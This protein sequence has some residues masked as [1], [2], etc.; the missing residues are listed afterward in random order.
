MRTATK[1]GRPHPTTSMFQ[2]SDLLHPFLLAANYPNASPALL[3]LSFKAMKTLLEANAVSPGDGINL[4][5]V[6]M[7]QTQ[8]VV[9]YGTVSSNGVG[10]DKSSTS[11]N[12]KDG[13][14][15]GGWVGSLISSSSN[16][17]SAGTAEPPSAATS[18]SIMSAV[19]SSHGQAGTPHLNN[20]ELDK[21]ALDILSCLL[22]LLELRDLPVPGEQW[23]Q[24]FSIC[25]HLYE[26]KSKVIRQA[27]KSTLPQVLGLLF[28][29]ENATLDDFKL[30]TWN[31]LVQCLQ[32]SKQ[33]LNGAFSACHYDQDGTPQPPSIPLALELLGGIS[34][35]SPKYLSRNTIDVL[36]QVLEQLSISSHSDPL[37]FIRVLQF[38]MLLFQSQIAN[39]DFAA[40]CR[41]LLAK[42]AKPI[43]KAT[44]SLRS[45]ADFEDGYIFQSGGVASDRKSDGTVKRSRNQSLQTL[46]GMSPTLLSKAAL[47]T[48]TILHIIQDA[49]LKSLWSHESILVQLLEA[50]SD[51]CTIGA[52]CEAHMML[53]VE[54][55]HSPK[56]ILKLLEPLA[57]NDTTNLK[58]WQQGFSDSGCI[59]S[60]AI[61]GDAMRIGFASILKM[62]EALDESALEAGFAPSLSVLQ[63]YLKRFPSSSLIV[64]RALSGYTSLARVTLESGDLLRRALLSSL[65]KLS[66][67]RWGECDAS[68]KLQDHN[69]AALICLVTIIHRFYN[70]IGS[71]WQIIFQ[72]FQELSVLSIA[73]PHLSDSAYIGALSISAVFG[74]FAAFSTCLS[75]DSLIELVRCLKEVAQ[76]EQTTVLV[77]NA[78]G[79]TS[80][81]PIPNRPASFDDSTKRSSSLDNAEADATIGSK[82]M[83]L[84]ARAVYGKENG[85]EGEDVPVAERTKANYFHDYQQEFT[86]RLRSSKQPLKVDE[87]PFS[88]ILLADIAMTNS[89]RYQHCGFAVIEQLCS[90]AM[91]SP[92]VQQFS[93]NT[94]AMIIMTHISGEGNLPVVS[95]GRSKILYD[96]PR[97][98]QY[99]A[100]GPTESSEDIQNA[101]NIA[102]SQLFAPLCN[103]V[104][105]AASHTVVE[106]SLI[107]L[108]LIL[109][110]AGHNLHEDVWS[111]LIDAVGSLSSDGRSAPE[112]MECNAIGFKC[113]KLIVDDFLHQ[114]DASLAARRSLL[115][116]CASF[117][118]SRHDMNTSLTAIGLLW[119]I[120]DQD[121]G[122]DA[123]DVSGSHVQNI[124]LIKIEYF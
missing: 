44:E 72:T 82:L 1:E 122:G 54:A 45:Q 38:T 53:L 41:A 79:G 105:A 112:W 62:I 23:V 58:W 61:F 25:C 91:D 89:F 59:D 6:W 85:S 34:Q 119:S 36:S 7:I 30:Q 98:N 66:L 51:L 4:V 116:C 43:V 50:C 48:E 71:E 2:S 9:S 74:R 110:N 93:M 17:S 56:P 65:C 28:S 124:D 87:L 49:S 117:G 81:I 90:L 99:L 111:I 20:K 10:K 86:S 13:S 106:S 67:P 8:V 27:A 94:V 101:S 120:A 5:R 100:V 115:D 107:S 42:L 83:S 95:T 123:I 26:A 29:H 31:D 77:P 73:S 52:S 84:G 18:T 16:S 39:K 35:S 24:S 113:L 46:K 102:Q 92:S 57:I 21:L 70:S 19:S 33:P 32:P 69:I 12:R 37:A 88:I 109:E 114:A 103:C 104:R 75:N 11:S 96:E 121:S 108:H 68:C 3:E 55:C 97:Q 63:H 47:C 118:F 22:Q 60:K 80:N 15:S 64:K 14:G 76:L 40:D 78:S